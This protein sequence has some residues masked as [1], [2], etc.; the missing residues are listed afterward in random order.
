MTSNSSQRM[1]KSEF[2]ALVAMLF[3]T[4]AFSV[5]ALLPAIP[6]IEAELDAP[7]LAY[8]LLTLFMGG[9][10]VGTLF[11]GPISD[12]LGRKPVM[13]LGAFLYI[14]AGLFAW[15][16]DNFHAILIAR[17]LQG[18][19]AA[20]PRVV[21]LAIVRD[22][23]SGAAMARIVSLAMVLFAIVPTIAPAMG[24]MMASTFGWRSI[25]LA[26]VCFMV[27]STFWLWLRLDESLPKEER[28]PFRP[29]LLIAAASEVVTHPV[30]RLAILIQG[31]ATS[32]IICLLVQVQPIYDQIF[33]LADSF[34]Y[35]FGGIAL[36]SAASTSLVNASLVTRFGMR[37][38]VTIGLSG[39]VIFA[40]ITLL[41]TTL[42]PK[43]AFLS[44]VIWQFMVIWLTGLSVGNL[45]AIALE[46]M[47]HIAG[48]TASLTGAIGT[49]IASLAAMYVGTLF[50]GTVLPLLWSELAL[51]TV[52]LL[53]MWRLNTR[54]AAQAG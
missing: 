15:Q 43:F 42:A 23:F 16:S 3:S 11:A 10:A 31:V 35:W 39:Q 6:Q 47:G 29:G 49:M 34:P 53:L 21:S 46:P 14:G 25:L 2:V 44:F 26:F 41:V 8:Q 18:V 13:Y 17:F 9:L 5:D 20:G 45:N 7:G 22:L 36:V 1:S 38:M 28:R 32:L 37:R 30:V 51:A 27:F 50:N 12:A 54:E 4:V 48:L 40:S 33:G 24:A 19:G 52:G